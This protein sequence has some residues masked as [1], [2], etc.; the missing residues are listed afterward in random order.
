MSVEAQKLGIH[1]PA[2][3][4]A[5]K[6]LAIIGRNVVGAGILAAG[7]AKRLEPISAIIAKP[8]FPLGGCVPIAETWVRRLEDLGVSELAM[9][10]HRVPE[11][12]KGHFGNGEKFLVNIN[13][14][15]E[16]Q[17]SGTLGGALKMMRALKSRINGSFT[18]MIVPSGDI[19]SEIS[20]EDFE[21]MLALHRQNGAA[22]TLMLTSVPWERVREFGTAQLQGIELKAGSSI[23]RS[24]FGNLV[25]FKEKDP[26][27]TS[28]LINASCYFIE[29]RFLEDVEGDL[30]ECTTDTS[31]V[32]EPFHD[33]GRQV[34]PAMLGKLPY[35]SHLAKYKDKL[36][37]FVSDARWFDVGRK[38][39]YLDVNKA[40]L[41]GQVNLHLPY[42][43]YSWGWI[44][45]GVDID[46][47]K[48]TIIPPVVIGNNCEILDGA[49]IGPYAVI[50]DG[51]LIQE[52]ARVQNSVLWQHLPYSNISKR[53]MVNRGVTVSS[54][55]V[56]GGTIRSDV[57][58][59]TVDVADNGELIISD[60][61]TVPDGPRA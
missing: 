47:A 41:D 31:L 10:L 9:N 18:T 39:D 29:T 4:G 3:Y 36:F 38:R 43:K 46:L 37:G 1:M 16:A 17:P 13:Y 12:I 35:K 7:V 24:T 53:R 49:V 48:V 21:R 34:F 27:S 60:I 52:D 32:P 55:I 56:V 45:S 40:V 28:N 61:D 51:W 57:S 14:V 8:A 6:R 2:A 44:G 5:G 59:K 54:S 22:V 30:T 25:D 23:P 50:G 20:L 11:S 19:V 42:N 58:N 15:D 26:R 33:F